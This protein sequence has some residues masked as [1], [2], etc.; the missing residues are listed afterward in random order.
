M[1]MGIP[2]PIN[3]LTPE[4]QKWLDDYKKKLREKRRQERGKKES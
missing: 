3:T 2:K 1:A 4:Q